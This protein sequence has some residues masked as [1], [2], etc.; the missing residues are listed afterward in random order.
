[1]KESS[2]IFASYRRWMLGGLTAAA[3]GLSLCSLA[4]AGLPPVLRL[5][6][7]GGGGPVQGLKLLYLPYF[8]GMLVPAQTA[9]SGQSF[10]GGVCLG[11]LAMPPVL[12]LA[13]TPV[14]R[15]LFPVVYCAALALGTGIAAAAEGRVYRTSGIW[16]SLA[17]L[18]GS[19]L[20][21]LILTG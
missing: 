14:G 1:M 9:L 3:L 4:G 8:L 16:V 5:I 15:S 20:I 21:I 6:V 13:G 12:L 7:P 10:W 11:A 17:C 2:A 18:Y 19:A